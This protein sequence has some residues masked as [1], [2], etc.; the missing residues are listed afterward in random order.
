MLFLSFSFFSSNFLLIHFLFYLPF[1]LLHICYLSCSPHSHFHSLSWFYSEFLPFYFHFFPFLSF[2]FLSFP[3]L[4]LF[5]SLSSVYYSLFYFPYCCY[6]FALHLSTITSFILCN[7][8]N[9][10]LQKDFLSLLISSATYS[11]C[12]IPSHLILLF[13][14]TLFVGVL[15]VSHHFCFYSLLLPALCRYNLP[16][17]SL[18]ILLSF[19]N[20]LFCCYSCHTYSLFLSYLSFFVSSC[21]LL[22]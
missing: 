8:C 11:N 13:P 12:L 5:S 14:L 19:A 16:H 20:F 1:P 7:S 4:Y 6:H 17:H 10:A 15:I 21:I 2:P 18:L 22:Y 9:S 3:F